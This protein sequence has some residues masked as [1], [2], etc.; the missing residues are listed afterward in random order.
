MSVFLEILL[1]FIII[2]IKLLTLL[3]NYDAECAAEHKLTGQV[4]VS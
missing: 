1:A 2:F 4:L 3:Q